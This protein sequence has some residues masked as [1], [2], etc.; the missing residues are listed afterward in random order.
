MDS[1]RE[2]EHM[3]SSS[4]VPLVYV[5]S[6]LYS[7]Q[8]RFVRKNLLC[9]PAFAHPVKLLILLQGRLRVL[10]RCRGVSKLEVAFGASH[11]ARLVI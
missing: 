7:V 1:V 11:E 9:A 10:Q 2:H 5:Y 8:F 6:C 3:L 4:T